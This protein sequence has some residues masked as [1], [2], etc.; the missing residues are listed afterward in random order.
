MSFCSELFI[1]N[2]RALKNKVAKKKIKI[3]KIKLTENKIGKKRRWNE[4]VKIE[5]NFCVKLSRWFFLLELKTIF[6]TWI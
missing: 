4:S 1:F 2:K 6:E 5:R 3:G